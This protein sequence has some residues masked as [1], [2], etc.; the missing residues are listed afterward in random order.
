MLIELELL[1]DLNLHQNPIREVADYRLSIVYR[2]PK[3]TTLDRRKIDPAEKV[4]GNSL[5]NPTVEYIASRD[6]MTNLVFSFIQD[7][8][9]KE[10]YD[11]NTLL[12]LHVPFTNEIILS[13]KHFT[14]Y[15]ISLS[16]TY[17]MWT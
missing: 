1:R 2:L 15:R 8:R 14:K 11:I 6:H 7:H 9:V 17:T 3:L 12:S 4:T 10:R 5:F 13:L 16:N